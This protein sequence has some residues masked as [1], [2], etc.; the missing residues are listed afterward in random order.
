MVKLR[1][2]SITFAVEVLV[3]DGGEEFICSNVVKLC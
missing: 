1:D 2:I 3:I